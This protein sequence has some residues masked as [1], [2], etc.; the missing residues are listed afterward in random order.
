MVGLI[1]ASHGH[2]SEGVK[3]AASLIFGEQEDV[4]ACTLEPSQGPDDIRKQMTDAIEA[5]GDKEIVFLVDLWG[6]TPFNQANGLF[7]GHED[8]WAIVTGL[9]LPMLI[10]AYGA[11]MMT[12][13]AHEVAQAALKTGREEVKAKPEEVAAAVASPAE[14]KAAPV[15][16][17]GAIPEGTVLGNGKIDYV[18][19]RIDTRLLHG[20]V[21][22]S[23]TRTTNPDR[24]IVVSDKV[25][26]DA[27]RKQMIME[28]EPPG[29]KAHVVPLAK[30][31]AVD[32]DTRFGDTRAML[33]F[34]NPQ[35]LLAAIEGGMDIKEVN[36]GSIAYSNGKVVLNNAVAMD[37]ED[38][39]AFEKMQKLGVTFNVRKVPADEKKA[40]EPLLKKAHAELGF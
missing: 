13:S 20:Q 6:G 23:W 9:N 8:K 4:F 33:L 10:E 12:D 18:L 28:A 29:V 24:I 7:E 19:V 2:L 16:A 11:R 15:A 26:H 32:K 31:I 27:L 38:V 17:V 36:V 22:T 30:M 39:E 1:L 3:E 21:A 25:S 5:I 35:D 37:R 40:L 34:E 14:E